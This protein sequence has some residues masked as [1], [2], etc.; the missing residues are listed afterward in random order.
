MLA[1]LIQIIKTPKA[2]PAELAKTI[3]VRGVKINQTQVKR[4][5]DFY[6]LQKKA[7]HS[8]SLKTR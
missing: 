8:P 6:A 3:R 5:I 7:E 1:V 4:V 2:D